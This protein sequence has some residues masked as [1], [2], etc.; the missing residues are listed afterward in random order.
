MVTGE[1][2]RKAEGMLYRH[3]RYIDSREKLLQEKDLLE[4]QIENIKKDIAETTI[5]DGISGIDYSGVRVQ[6]S[7]SLCGIPERQ[8]L[9][10]FDEIERLE[11]ELEQKVRR[12]LKVQ[13][14]LRD[15]ES[16]IA[17]V[18]YAVRKFD[19]N[20]KRLIEYRYGEGSSFEYIGRVLNMGRNT[21]RRRREE[22]VELVAKLLNVS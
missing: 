6:T 2:F 1:A 3:Y 22:I 13:A 19:E 5:S 21:A 9:I 18:D 17:H 15:Y 16:R 11:K 7:P 4:R 10:L 20:T 12:K 8:T 14:K